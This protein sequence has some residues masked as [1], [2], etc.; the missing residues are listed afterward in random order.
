MFAIVKNNQVVQYIQPH[1]VFHVNWVEYGADWIATATQEQKDAIG[2]VDVVYGQQS[3]GRFYWVTQQEPVYN[4]GAKQVEINF[5]ATPK[6]LAQ[7]KVEWIA[8]TK[9]TAGSLLSQTDWMVIRKAERDVAIPLDVVAARGAIILDQD[10]KQQAIEAATTV[11]E[12]I[13]AVQN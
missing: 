6:D 11:E 10:S 13:A 7:L 1:G 5:T 2:L 8:Q 4:A 3:D 9:A 12:L